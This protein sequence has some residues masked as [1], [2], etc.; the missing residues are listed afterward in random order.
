[1]PPKFDLRLARD[2]NETRN[3]FISGIALSILIVSISSFYYILCAI[4]STR[5][6]VLVHSLYFYGGI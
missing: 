3:I 6:N 4:L 2:E 5:Y 1:M